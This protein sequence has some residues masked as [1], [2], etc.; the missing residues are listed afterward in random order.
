MN[1]LIDASEGREN[2]FHRA[3]DYCKD[4]YSFLKI[5]NQS[6]AAQ[7]EAAIAAS[8]Q[9][10]KNENKIS[11]NEIDSDIEIDNNDRIEEDSNLENWKDY[12]GPDDGKEAKILF[13]FPDGTKEQISFPASSHALKDPRFEPISKDEMPQLYVGVS[14]L[15]NFEDGQNYLD[16]EV[17]KHGIIIKFHSDSGRKLHATFLPEVAPEQGMPTMNQPPMI[18]PNQMNPYP[19]A[20]PM[21]SPTMMNQ[22]QQTKQI[23]PD[24]VPSVIQVTES[25]RNKFFTKDLTYSTTIPSDLP[26]NETTIYDN[27]Q[28]FL[29]MID[30]GC[31]RPNHIR[32]SIYNVPIKEEILKNT[33]IPF[34]VVVKPFDEFEVDDKFTV[35]VSQ[36]EIIRCNRCKAYISP[37]MKFTDGGKRFQCSLC[38]HMND[39]PPN[40]FVSLD[41][42]EQRLDKYERPELHLGSYEFRTGQE[43]YRNK[44]LASR[45]PHIVFAFE[46][47]VNSKPL[48]QTISEHLIDVIKT[49]LP[50]DKIWNCPPPLIGFMTY[51][52]KIQFYDVVNNGTSHII[53]DVSS[54]FPPFTTFLVDPVTQIDKIEQFLKKLPSLYSDNELE[55]ETI[56]GP[57]IEAAFQTC[58]A[59]SSNWFPNQEVK[60]KSKVLAV[61]KIY[62]FHC[63]LPTFGQDGVT[64][65]RLKKRWTTVDDEAKRL[66]GTD[67]EKLILTPESSKYYTKLGEKCVSEYGS[68]VE[69]FLFPPLNG[70]FVD[71][72]TISELIRLT[73]TGG[74]YKYFNDFSP[75]FIEDLKT[76]LQSTMAFD[77]ILKVRT[78]TGIRPV[79]YYGNYYFSNLY[80]VEFAALNAGNSI[81]VEFKY[82]E[83]LNENQFV[84][85]QVAALYTSVSGDRRVRVHNL[86]LPVCS[87][88]GEVY[89]SANCDALMNH[90]F[91]S[92]ACRTGDVAE[93]KML[94][95]SGAALTADW[96]GTSPLH[97]ASQFGHTETA[98]FLLKAGASRDTRTKVDRT[99]LHVAALEGHLPIVSLLLGNGAEID[100]KDL[101][102]MTP[103]H[104]AVERGHFEVVEYLLA[105]GSDVNLQS[106]FDKTPIDI[107]YDSGRT[108]MIPLLEKYINSFRPKNNQTLAIQNVKT[109]PTILPNKS[110]RTQKLVKNA[111]SSNNLNDSSISSSVN[112]PLSLE[113]IKKF[114][115]NNNTVVKKEFSS[116]NKI[117]TRSSSIQNNTATLTMNDA[118]ETIQWLEKNVISSSTATSTIL[119]GKDD[120]E[121]YQIIQKSNQ[122]NNSNKSSNLKNNI[123]TITVNNQNFNQ[124]IKNTQSSPFV[125]ISGNEK[126]EKKKVI[127]FEKNNN[128]IKS[129]NTNN[130]SASNYSTVE[131]SDQNDDCI[132]YSMEKDQL[133]EELLSIKNENKSL[134][135]EL[136]TIKSEKLSL[137]KELEKKDKII[138]DLRKKYE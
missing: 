122:Q 81:S 14:I 45:R 33:S 50:V 22:P 84:I 19:T 24:N 100:A 102:K 2:T 9:E 70:S 8:L 38:H 120:D 131:S 18:P 16:W 63:S 17:G 87:Q 42:M 130:V 103:L 25:D 55:T 3:M 125:L 59:D 71:I 136:K 60:D 6:E 86:V 110:N 121:D 97:L 37:H 88:I 28:V 57:V 137:M 82:D 54:T 98:D 83:K 23:D 56:L 85:I 91:R 116:A 30:N 53:S 108:E 1:L 46:L 119:N 72:A 26:P 49:S 80:D 89:R 132:D 101:L 92:Y 7:I 12:L 77:V 107:A 135:E 74:I 73:G 138:D 47:T 126:D 117:T 61:G 115:N 32:S 10:I 114:I 11:E 128:N 48:I 21:V 15:L 5:Y 93:V 118:N 127:K 113:N 20:N 52:S 134:K 29:K 44:V 106:K 13:R 129:N 90:L 111:I 58:N 76:S 62:L 75:R 68:G 65:G 39:V 78:S 99:P 40:Y 31:A 112:K 35:P 27:N 96:L 79:N 94:V 69:L 67:K 51:N 43:F 123:I 104:W 133:K 95:E 105:H 64:P 66:L 41:H 109:R 4:P 34:N 124:L 36:S